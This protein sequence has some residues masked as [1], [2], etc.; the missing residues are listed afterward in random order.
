VL[1]NINSKTIEAGISFQVK[2]F[3]DE[4]LKILFLFKLI[5]FNWNNKIENPLILLE[6]TKLM[7]REQLK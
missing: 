2:Y 7:L 4:T 6:D 5:I 1:G 3:I